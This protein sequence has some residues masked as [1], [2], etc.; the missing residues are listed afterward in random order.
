MLS[1]HWLFRLHV[2][3]PLNVEWSAEM[4]C[5]GCSINLSFIDAP[6]EVVTL[7]ICSL[8]AL[9]SVAY[10]F[11]LLLSWCSLPV[12]SGHRNQVI[13][14]SIALPRKL[15]N[16]REGKIYRTC[17]EFYYTWYKG[18]S[19][20]VIVNSKLLDLE[21]CFI[22]NILVGRVELSCYHCYEKLITQSQEMTSLLRMKGAFVDSETRLFWFLV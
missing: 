11:Y 5:V 20:L 13:S 18:K 17:K 7:F 12:T 16:Y 14:L 9:C 15:L 8:C 4:E 1:R 10:Q 3:P 22:L 21:S 2:T 19:H 6:F